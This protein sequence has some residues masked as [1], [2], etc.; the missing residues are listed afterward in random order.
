[1]S[2][3]S[4][5]SKV[6]QFKGAIDAKRSA[7]FT[8]LSHEI[9]VAVREKGPDASFNIRLRVA[10]D[11]AKKGFMPKDNIER[12]IKRGTGEGSEG[13]QLEQLTYEA[14]GP[15]RSALII[16][17]V[18]DNRNRSVADIKTILMKNGGTFANAGSVT[19][20]FDRLGVVR[21]NGSLPADRKDEIELELIDAG[22]MD[23][24]SADDGTEIFTDPTHLARVA[25]EVQKQN[26]TIES[27]QF[28]WIAKMPIELNEEDGTAVANLVELLDENDD[29]SQVY[30]NAE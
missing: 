25:D 21:V 22:A 6:K 9:T 19:H 20:L 15:G 3:H 12:A 23:I 28:E 5:W 30:T 4:K 11:R 26:L 27:A 14:Y 2:R 8:K 17:C 29:V 16:E 18:T 10:I 7:S 13:A 1:M 24:V